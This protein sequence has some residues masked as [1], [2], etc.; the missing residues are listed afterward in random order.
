MY[1]ISV[2]TGGIHHPRHLHNLLQHYSMSD[3]TFHVLCN[4]DCMMIASMCHCCQAV[5]RACGGRNRY[6]HFVHPYVTLML[7]YMYQVN[8]Q[9][10]CFGLVHRN[11]LPMASW[12]LVACIM[13]TSFELWK[14]IL[15]AFWILYIYIYIRGTKNKGT[16]N[17]LLEVTFIWE[18]NKESVR[19]V[20]SILCVHHVQQHMH[21]I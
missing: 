10:S 15:S 18:A 1:W 2:C 19:N 20:L 6:W 3:R 14:S 11:P 5:I 17:L 13:S 12:S 7:V 8:F 4:Y 9:R 16:P 21:D